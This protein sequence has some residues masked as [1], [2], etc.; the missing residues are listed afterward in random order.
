M[1][2]L[3]CNVHQ[4]WLKAEEKGGGLTP[5]KPD[6]W[7]SRWAPEGLELAAWLQERSGCWG[8]GY[9]AGGGSGIKG[10]EAIHRTEQLKKKKKR[11]VSGESVVMAREAAVVSSMG[12]CLL[13][14]LSR[15]SRWEEMVLRVVWKSKRGRIWLWVIATA[16][17][18]D[19]ANFQWR[20]RNSPHTPPD[21]LY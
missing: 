7:P 10:V 15:E 12:D 16:A 6:P 5:P 3:L 9:S 4:G 19:S 1:T 13:K 18:P 11:S 17:Y 2:A 20:S 21:P 14:P 8:E